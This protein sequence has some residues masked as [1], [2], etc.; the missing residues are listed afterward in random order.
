M[1]KKIMIIA[2]IAVA[3]CLFIFKPNKKTEE[4]NA[5]QTLTNRIIVIDP[6]HGGLDNGANVGKVR[7]DQLN[8]KISLALKEELE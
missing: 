5:E 7:E 3:I 6:G 8:L 4:V 1:Y 2:M